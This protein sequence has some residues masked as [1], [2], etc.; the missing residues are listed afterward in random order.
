[1]WSAY[2]GTVTVLNY[3]SWNLQRAYKVSSY[4]A[5]RKIVGFGTTSG[6]LRG[7]ILANW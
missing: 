7:F 6:A 4:A 3:T 1:M 2:Y 5:G